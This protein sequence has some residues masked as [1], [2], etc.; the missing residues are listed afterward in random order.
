M[1]TE[2]KS[3]S[4]EQSEAEYIRKLFQNVLDTI[5]VSVF[6]KDRDCTYEGGNIAFAR[7]AGFEHAEQLPGKSDYDA[8]W[9]EE[10]PSFQRDDKAVM[11]SGEPRLN[12]EE[13]QTRGDGSKKWLLTSKIPR[14]DSTGNIVGML[15]TYQDITSIKLAEEKVLNLN[16]HLEKQVETR[17]KE[18]QA[19][20]DKLTDTLDALSAAQNELV[21]AEK[22]A[23]LGGLVSGIAHEVNTPVGIAVT[24]SSHVQE[25]VHGLGKKL[26]NGTMRKSDLEDFLQVASENGTILQ[27]N[28]ARA[29]E[30]IKSFKQVAVDQ[31]T[32][33][34]RLINLLDY[35]N[36]V[37]LNHTPQLKKT[38]I[39][40]DVQID[41]DINLVTFPGAVSQI[42]SNLLMNSMIHAFEATQTGIILISAKTEGDQVSIL[43]SDDGAGMDTDSV[44]KVFDPFFTTKRGQGGSGL[45]M[46]IVYNL[47]TQKL[48]GRITLESAPGSGTRFQITLPLEVGSD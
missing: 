32:E 22:M 34:T 4:A 44:A 42:F 38:A 11:A 28:L 6:W 20:N 40:V 1:S 35:L 37:V 21:E 47:L 36:G 23:S 45:G 41:P 18:L 24:A 48:G 2:E 33:A 29:A 26:E 16:E 3:A 10:A 25:L 19:A 9:P 5:P 17:T 15:G 7:D 12:F 13:I 43:F 46:N 27:S 39:S 30:L 8:V 14:T 31:S